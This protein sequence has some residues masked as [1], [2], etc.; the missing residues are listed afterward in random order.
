MNYLAHLHLGGDQPEQL[1][2]SLFGDFVKG[3]LNG[4]WPAP[5]ERS[6]QLHR[7]IDAFT[8]AHP[9]VAQARERFA[10]SQRRYAGLVLDVFFDHCLARDW[11]NYSDR[12]LE[13]FSRHVYQALEQAPQ[14]PQ[15]LAPLVPRMIRQ[16]WLG[17]YR[18]FTTMQQVIASIDRRLSRPGLLTGMY[19]ELERLYEP[20][21]ADFQTL[22]PHLQTFAQDALRKP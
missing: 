18:D 6:I 1:L 14:L 17:S 10:A 22:Y 21:S 16:D 20:L 15:K 8:D 12:P 13:Q 4:Q 2:G 11:E 19:D 9:V 3:L 7:R 5:V